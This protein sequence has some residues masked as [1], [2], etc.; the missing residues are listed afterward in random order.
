MLRSIKS[1]IQG[2]LNQP[3]MRRLVIASLVFVTLFPVITAPAEARPYTTGGSQMGFVNAC[4]YNGGVTKR[5]DTYVVQCTLPNGYVIVCNFGTGICVDFPPSELSVNQ[6][7]HTTLE[8]NGSFLWIDSI[9]TVTTEPTS[10]D[11]QPTP[12]PTSTPSRR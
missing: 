3:I 7:T 5:L 9:A 4:R 10:R 2:H 1:R 8:S 12:T 11:T 6:A